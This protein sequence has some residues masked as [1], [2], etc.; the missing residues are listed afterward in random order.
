L[1]LFTDAYLADTE[2]LTDAE[3]GIYLKILMVM[4]RN[5]EC[6]IPNDNNWIARRLRR[7]IAEVEKDVLPIIAEFCQRDGNWIVQKRLQKEWK[8]C[9][10]K[11]K[12]N[13]A[14]AKTMWANKKLLS[15]RISERNANGAGLRNAP[16]PSSK[17]EEKRVAEE[18]GSKEER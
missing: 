3:N 9:A 11:R 15:E 4:W 1:P 7:T 17:L 10:E 2:H 5:P 8:W 14:S 12:K 16:H 6:R 18:E 13:S